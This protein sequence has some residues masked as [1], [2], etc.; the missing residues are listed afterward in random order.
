V[1]GRLEKNRPKF[2]K[3]SPKSCQT[4]NMAQSSILPPSELY[5]YQ[6][7][8][9]FSPNNFSGPLKSSPNGEILPNMVT[10]LGRHVQEP[11]QPIVFA[12]SVGNL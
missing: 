11:R 6:Q 12:F 10:L 9:I 3:S 7:Q 4:K 8:I 5:K 1:N 2:G